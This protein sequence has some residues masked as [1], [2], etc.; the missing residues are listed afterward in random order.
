MLKPVWASSVRRV[1]LVWKCT[2]V[3]G[4]RDSPAWG[5]AEAF[6]EWPSSLCTLRPIKHSLCSEQW[7]KDLWKD[8]WMGHDGFF[9]PK[10]FHLI[11]LSFPLCDFTEVHRRQGIKARDHLVLISGE[12]AGFTG[13]NGCTLL[14]KVFLLDLRV[15]SWTAS[16]GRVMKPFLW[17]LLKPQ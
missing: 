17:R 2:E 15:K 13:G 5:E 3:E 6:F 1:G 12:E 10:P 7:A 4:R 14:Y 16:L 8:L 11:L 9:W